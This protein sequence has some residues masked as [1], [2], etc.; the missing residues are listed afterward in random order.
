MS[1]YEPEHDY[2]TVDFSFS[3][4]QRTRTQHKCT[5]CQKYIPPNT[6]THV[7]FE[8]VEGANYYLRTCVGLTQ[9]PYYN[10]SVIVGP[11]H[12]VGYLVIGDDTVTYFPQTYIDHA[13]AHEASLPLPTLIEPISYL[14]PLYHPN[15]RTAS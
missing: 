13:I 7:T 5:T 15:Q 4:T 9:G 14:H 10:C 2:P 11:V 3:R 12:Q 6:L 8:R 1:Y